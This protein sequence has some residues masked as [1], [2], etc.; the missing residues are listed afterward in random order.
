MSGFLDR[1]APSVES[2]YFNYLDTDI[3][4]KFIFKNFMSNVIRLS[5]TQLNIPIRRH[6]YMGD[7]FFPGDV[8]VNLRE[9]TFNIE[10]KFAR[11]NIAH[12]T[13]RNPLA[14]WTIS[15]CTE[16]RAKR[17]KQPCDFFFAVGIRQHSIGHPDFWNV[18]PEETGI[19]RQM[20]DNLNQ[21]PP[22][23]D[24]AFLK[25]CGFFLIPYRAMSKDINITL[26]RF[27]NSPYKEF[28]C[29]GKDV[30]QCKAAWRNCISG[31]IQTKRQRDKSFFVN[32]DLFSQL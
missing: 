20:S 19:Y 29:W 28:F 8:Q 25:Y 22:P 17:P 24:A 11:V 26:G 21:L 13:R 5:E 3:L 1:K 9:G 16:T 27:S 12:R 31:V 30:K 15:R 32:K 10:I 6:G 14:R 2:E 7:Q 23:H 18:I 4:G